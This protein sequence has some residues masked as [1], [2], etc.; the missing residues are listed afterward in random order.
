MHIYTHTHTHTHIY[1]H[2]N[3][4]RASQIK[5]GTHTLLLQGMANSTSGN[6]IIVCSTYHCREV[7]VMRRH[8]R[9]MSKATFVSLLVLQV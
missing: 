1:T 2:T 6:V 3:T 4:E 5:R 7:C 8:I 9:T